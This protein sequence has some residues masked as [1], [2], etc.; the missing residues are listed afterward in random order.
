MSYDWPDDVVPPKP[1][2]LTLVERME[3]R[4]W[5]FVIWCALDAPLKHLNDWGMRRL[6]P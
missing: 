2:K 4:Y 6:T 1:V 3:R 5:G